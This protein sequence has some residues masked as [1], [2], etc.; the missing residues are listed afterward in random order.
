MQTVITPAHAAQVIRDKVR[1]LE[2]RNAAMAATA[3]KTAVQV[4]WDEMALSPVAVLTMP[5][6]AQ[7]VQS[8]RAK[9]RYSI[10]S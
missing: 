6:P 4:A 1:M 7:N 5:D 8:N 2:I 9:R 3:T 10:S